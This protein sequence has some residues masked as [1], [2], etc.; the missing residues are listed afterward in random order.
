MNKPV[1]SAWF[2]RGRML[3]KDHCWTSF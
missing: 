2:H 1:C 3:Y